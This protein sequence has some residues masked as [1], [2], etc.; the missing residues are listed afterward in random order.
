MAAGIPHPEREGQ[1][2]AQTDPQPPPTVSTSHINP[3]LKSFNFL[4]HFPSGLTPSHVFLQKSSSRKKFSKHSPL[5]LVNRKKRLSFKCFE[6]FCFSIEVYLLIKNLM[7]F[8]AGL[9]Y[10]IYPELVSKK[11]FEN[12]FPVFFSF[13]FWGQENGLEDEDV[14]KVSINHLV[15][16]V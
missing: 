12:F 15:V 3:L 13:C 8:L 6:Q 1:R 10:S 9:A 16:I 2:E 5:K 7:A 11:S 14:E 4:F